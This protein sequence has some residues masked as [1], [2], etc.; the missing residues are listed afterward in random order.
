MENASASSASL[1]H[2]M[3]GLYSLKTT[4]TYYW[5]VQFENI[6]RQRRFLEIAAMDRNWQVFGGI[7]NAKD[8]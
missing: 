4:S 5:T 6:M 8:L 2:L 7:V 3:I 1:V